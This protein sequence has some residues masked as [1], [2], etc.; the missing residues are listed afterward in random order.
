MKQ[1]DPDTTLVRSIESALDMGGLLFQRHPKHPDWDTTRPGAIP[2]EIACFKHS[3]DEGTHYLSVIFHYAGE[4]DEDGYTWN[5]DAY[6]IRGSHP[7]GNQTRDVL[8]DHKE[9]AKRVAKEMERRAK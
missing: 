4:T 1:P 5:E 3:T 7:Y 6:E 9:A 8:H 2:G